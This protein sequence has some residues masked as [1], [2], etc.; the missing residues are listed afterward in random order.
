MDELLGDF[1]T[2]TGERIDLL[3]PE[4]VRFEGQRGRLRSHH[5]R[6]GVPGMDGIAFDE[7][8]KEDGDWSEVFISSMRA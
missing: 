1:L 2:E 7:K 5:Q 8:L 4:L 3:E 6:S